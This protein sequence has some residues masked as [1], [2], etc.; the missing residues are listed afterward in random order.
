MHHF[1]STWSSSVWAVCEHSCTIN[2]LIVWKQQ[3]Q[4][5]QIT[6]SRKMESQAPSLLHIWIFSPPL[7]EINVL[8]CLLLSSGQSSSF[9]TNNT[10]GSVLHVL[11]N[12]RIYATE[13]KAA[14]MNS[15]LQRETHVC[16]KIKREKKRQRS[17]TAG[18][19]Q[20][21][22]VSSVVEGFSLLHWFWLK[23]PEPPDTRKCA[24][25]P[26]WTWRRRWAYMSWVWSCALHLCVRVFSR[27]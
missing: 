19:R 4:Q 6:G 1:L 27:L 24:F 8:L 15:V 16:E 11:S 18:F 23:A 10:D 21:V 2:S 26:V 22:S 25:V 3:Q 17:E 9:S 13:T 14:E 12:T 7:R 5:Q 20:S